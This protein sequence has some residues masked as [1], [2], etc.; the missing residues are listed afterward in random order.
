MKQQHALYEKIDEAQQLRLEM[1]DATMHVR[2]AVSFFC[3][4][5]MLP[6]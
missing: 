2:C 1:L 4:R 6:S 3:E 5:D